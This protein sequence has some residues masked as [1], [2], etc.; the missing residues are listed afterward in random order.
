MILNAGGYVG[1]SDNRVVLLWENENPTDSVYSQTI[2]VSLSS[3]KILFITFLIS[4]TYQYLNTVIVPIDTASSTTPVMLSSAYGEVQCNRQ[5]NITSEGVE[6]KS[7]NGND[8]AIP[9][10]IYGSY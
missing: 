10:R 9:Y 4:N 8:K 5:V 6:F 1:N 7:I 3:Y 2:N